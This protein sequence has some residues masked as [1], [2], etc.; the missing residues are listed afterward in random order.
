MKSTMVGEEPYVPYDRPSLS[1]EF[2]RGEKRRDELFFDPEQ[3]FH[4]QDIGL[5]LGVAVHVW[6]DIFD[7]HLEFAGDE[8]EHDQ[9]LFRGRF[10]NRSFTVIYLKRHILT[11]Y[12]AVNASSKEFPIL[13]HLIRHKR[14]LAGREL[15]L[16][17]PTDALKGLL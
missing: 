3:Y 2:L 6:S 4:D 7:L 14:D 8:T 15:Q 1:K 13:Q 10:E 12:F 17:D 11:A 5:V 9:V 16:Q